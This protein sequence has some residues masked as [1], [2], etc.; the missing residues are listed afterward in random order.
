MFCALETISGRIGGIKPNFHV[1][2]PRT[3]FR[4]YRGRQVPFAWFAL[5][6]SFSAVPRASGLIF[7]LCGSGL[8]FGSHFHISGG[9]EGTESNFQV[10]RYQTHFQRYQGRQVSYSCFALPDSFSAVLMAPGPIVMFCAPRPV[11]R[12]PRVPRAIFMFRAP[13]LIFGGTEGVGSHFHV[14]LFRTPFRWYEG[15]R[16]RFN[17]LRCRTRFG[18]YQ[19]LQVQFSC[20]A[21]PNPFWA[22]SMAPGP[23][24]MFC[25]IILILLRSRFDVLRSRTRFGRYREFMVP[26]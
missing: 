9:T 24:F 3:L 5:P 23:V 17:V 11:L 10:S 16:S 2:R 21:L 4:R 14:L 22:L 20:F 8:I 19:G 12:K 7:M 26:F 1:S 6:N 15:V 13:G 18:W 25:A